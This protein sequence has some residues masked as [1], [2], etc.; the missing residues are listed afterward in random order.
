MPSPAKDAVRDKLVHCLLLRLGRPVGTH[1]D[2]HCDEEEHARHNNSGAN[3]L[4]L[5]NLNGVDGARAGERPHEASGGK[6]KE[7]DQQRAQHAPVVAGVRARS[8]PTRRLLVPRGSSHLLLNDGM[9]DCDGDDCR[10]E[11]QDRPEPDCFRRRTPPCGSEAPT[12][13]DLVIEEHL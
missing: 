13:A 4:D 1:V 7:V 6:G 12:E 8:M 3:E 11:E 5:P 10:V 2:V 9:D